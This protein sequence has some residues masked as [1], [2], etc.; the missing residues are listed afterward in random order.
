M[1]A[2]DFRSFRIDDRVFF[3]D[4]FQHRCS[5]FEMTKAQAIAV[6]ISV[7][8]ELLFHDRDC[9]AVFQQ[10]PDHVEVVDAGEISQ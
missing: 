6:V 2:T 9:G 10:N 7:V 1:F 4:P 3:E 5:V 8:I